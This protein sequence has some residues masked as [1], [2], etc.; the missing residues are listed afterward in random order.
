ML[1]LADKRCII[2]VD[3]DFDKSKFQA[4]VIIEPPSQFVDPEKSD[5]IDIVFRHDGD[6]FDFDVER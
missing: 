3:K 2:L 6:I 4:A 5:S 1:L